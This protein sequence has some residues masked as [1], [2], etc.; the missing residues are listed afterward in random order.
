VVDGKELGP[1]FDQVWFSDWGF[2]R[3]GSH[4]FVSGR[5]KTSWLHAVDG[6]PTPGFDV[7]SRVAFTRDGRHYAY[8][9]AD[10]HG[11]MKKQKVVGTIVMDG[12]T[13]ATYE[14]KGMPGAWTALGGEREVMLGGVRDLATDFHGVSTPEFDPD[15]KLVYAARRDKGDVAVFRGQ[16]S[17]PGFDEVLSPVVFTEDSSHFVYIA[18]QG[19]DFVEVR[20]N[21]I[22]RTVPGGKRGASAVGFVALTKDSSHIAYETISGGHNYKVAATL[23]AFR[24]VIIDGQAGSE[25]NALRLVNFDFDPESRHYFYQV[26]GAEGDRSLVNIDGHESRLCDF[27]AGT[28]YLPDGKTIAFVARDGSRFLRFTYTLGPTTS[29]PPVS[30][31][32]LIDSETPGSHHE[33]FLVAGLLP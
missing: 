33:A 20:D 10:A 23:R 32:A 11:G 15:G 2:S 12:Q 13:V 28:R 18:R 24:T 1:E 26:I 8:G 21:K 31:A 14:G 30:T 29:I 19:S 17:G 6:T 16:D 7:I 3:D 27:V 5:L 9:G 4:F 22:V 25:Y